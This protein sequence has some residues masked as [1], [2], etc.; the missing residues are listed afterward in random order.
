[1]SEILLAVDFGGSYTSIYRKDC[2]LV[3]KEPTLI[4]AVLT[5]SGYEVKVMGLGAKEIMG[6]TDD[7]TVVFS[8]IAE[9]V[10]KS[11]EY[12]TILL[13]YFLDKVVPKKS[14]FTKIKCLV[15]YPTG[16]SEKEIQEYKNVFLN[17]GASEVVFV[18]RLLC[19]C[20]GGGV[21][22]FA[23]SA[24]LALDIGGVSTDVGV[25]NLGSLIN[26]ATLCVGGKA[27]DSQIIRTVS[28]KY[29]VEIGLSSAQKLKEEIGS[30]YSN[31]TANMEVM[32]VDINTKSPTSVVVYATDVKMSV[33]PLLTEIARVVETTL[34]II[35]PEISADV[36]KNGVLVTGGFACLAGM[37]RYLQKELNLPITIADDAPNA[38]ILGAGKLLANLDAL[39]KVLSEL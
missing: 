11:P 36:A 35:P 18:P 28:A 27:I 8:P 17:V 4:G 19:S 31:D 24:H 1:M 7:R 21:N 12:A 34:N 29:G 9:G 22:I 16:L 20:Y 37:K 15:P 39:K 13:K 3:L 32:G 2:G 14:I 26:G 25:V 6:K 38:C 10:I 5:N 33:L 30:L 23:N